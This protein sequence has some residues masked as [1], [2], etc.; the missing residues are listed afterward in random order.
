MK[1]RCLIWMILVLIVNAAFAERV[2][3]SYPQRSKYKKIFNKIVTSYTDSLAN[4]VD[5]YSQNTSPVVTNTKM[6]P[7]CYK[8]FAPVTVYESVV[9]NSI[10]GEEETPATDSYLIPYSYISKMELNEAL[11]SSIDN[12]LMSVYLNEPRSVRYMEDDIMQR[13]TFNEDVS[14][15]LPRQE[16]MTDFLV[17]NLPDNDASVNQK[18]KKPNFWTKKGNA[19]LQF[20]QSYISSNWYNGGESNNT[21]LS[22]VELEANYNDQQ[23]VE[24]DNKFEWKLGFINSRSDSLHRYKTNSDLLRLTS[25]FGYKAI[26]YWYYTIQLQFYTQLFESYDSNDPELN[27]N[28]LS[29]GYFKVDLGMDYKRTM[30]NWEVSAVLAPLSY[31]LTYV[32]DDKVDET[33]YDLDEG[34]KIMHELGSNIQ[35][36]SKWKISSQ[37]EWQSQLTYFTTYVKVQ[38]E[39]ENTLNFTLN[40]YLST[41]IFVH[42]R[43]DDGASRDDGDSYFQLKEMLSFGLSYTW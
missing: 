25:K 4:V 38:A 42:G 9:E 11:E 20:T 16:Q 2:Y 23:R 24:W 10:N 14:S 7:H 39:W 3:Q 36:T 21:F 15:N 34:D 41:K 13:S 30:K 33:D 29:P 17:T 28:F 19:Y 27:S 8:L 37:I 6:N 18:L 26:K 12:T 22:G 32:R 35:L 31:K 40:K 43:F 1:K 5:K